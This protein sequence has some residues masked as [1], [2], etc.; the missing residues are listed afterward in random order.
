MRC[1][2]ERLTYL[3]HMRSM[4]SDDQ[5]SSPQLR[6]DRIRGSG[7][8]AAMRLSKGCCDGDNVSALPIAPGYNGRTTRVL[9]PLRVKGDPA[10]GL[11]EVGV[12][13]KTYSLLVARLVAYIEVIALVPGDAA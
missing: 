11:M 9:G 13:V 8:A 4:L 7:R 2:S 3:P 6:D 10:T 5:Q 12:M 1:L